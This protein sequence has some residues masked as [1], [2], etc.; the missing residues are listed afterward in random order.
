MY[1]FAAR[2]KYTFSTQLPMFRFGTIFAFLFDMNPRHPHPNTTQ[3]RPA[4]KTRRKAF[5]VSIL[6]L[7]L[8]GSQGSCQPPGAPQTGVQ[9]KTLSLG[10]CM[11]RVTSSGPAKKLR[12]FDVHIDLS[13]CPESE[14]ALIVLH[15]DMPGMQMGVAPVHAVE[16][17]PGKYRADI[18]FTMGGSWEIVFSRGAARAVWEIHVD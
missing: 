16:E 12:P 1:L 15:A 7:F 17:A 10:T 6:M 11:A 3:P 2:P 13:A 14:S 4:A 18:V 9:E 5:T 8:L